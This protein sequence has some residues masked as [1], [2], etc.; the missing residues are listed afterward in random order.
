MISAPQK[1]IL[2]VDDDP[3]I[4]RLLEVCLRVLPAGQIAIGGGAAA[5]EVL[6]REKVDLVVT[7]LMMPGTGG[8]EIVRAM[9]AD[10]SWRE[11]PV[12]LL[13]CVGNPSLPAEAKDAGVQ[14]YFMK[15]FSPSQLVATAR[16]LLAL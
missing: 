2:I 1:K 7:D 6:R 9:R 15:P 10:P 4:R 12:V 14:A 8:F 13:S 11:I 16:R 5:L 3:A